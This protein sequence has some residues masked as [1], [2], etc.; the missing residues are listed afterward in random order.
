MNA[1]NTPWL[2]FIS[3]PSN[4]SP[5]I[6]LPT[7]INMFCYHLSLA[8]TIMGQIELC[9]QSSKPTPTE[10]QITPPNTF[11]STFL[12]GSNFN[13]RIKMHFFFCLLLE[14]ETVIHSLLKLLLQF[15]RKCWWVSDSKGYLIVVFEPN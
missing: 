13:K 8:I 15:E 3:S 5:T 12:P 2:L 14:P 11:P 1:T 10:L 6:T 7:N 9:C 4:S